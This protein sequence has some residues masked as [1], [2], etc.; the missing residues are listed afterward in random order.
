MQKKPEIKRQFEVIDNGEKTTLGICSPTQRAL[1]EAAMKYS[2]IFSDAVRQ[3]FLLNTEVEKI[4]KDRGIWGPEKQ[5]EIEGVV[6]EIEIKEGFIKDETV[7]KEDKIKIAYELINLRDKKFKMQREINTIY[8]NTAENRAEE[9]RLQFLTSQ[10]IVRVPNCEKFFRNYEDFI[11]KSGTPAAGEAVY[12]LITFMNGLDADFLDKL[13]ES[14]YIKEEQ[15]K[16]IK[17]LKKASESL[18]K[19]AEVEKAAEPQE[20]I[21]EIK[22][23]N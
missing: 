4:I 9:A 2:K 1:Q 15:E 7:P 14:P 3:G 20:K 6:E 17:E 10:C 18:D 5:K 23:N 21:E 19:K 8:N 13:P 11:E 22:K 12:Q 16:I